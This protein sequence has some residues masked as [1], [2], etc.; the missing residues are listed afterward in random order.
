MPPAAQPPAPPAAEVAGPLAEVPA[1]LGDAAP[2][3]ATAK[4]ATVGDA[5]ARGDATAELLAARAGFSGRQ[6]SRALALTLSAALPASAGEEG[7]AGGEKDEKNAEEEC[8]ERLFAGDAALASASHLQSHTPRADPSARWPRVAAL[9][10]SMEA[11][12]R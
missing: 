9:L 11:E 7:G 3:L 6:P 1:L 12:A 4:E 10:G 8:I 5:S 2:F